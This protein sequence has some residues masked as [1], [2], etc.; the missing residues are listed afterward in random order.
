MNTTREAPDIL[1]EEFFTDPYSAYQVMRDEYP[2][3]WHEPM[4][5]LAIAQ[6]GLAAYDRAAGD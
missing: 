3:I 1:S 2:L 6:A 4:Q 5:S